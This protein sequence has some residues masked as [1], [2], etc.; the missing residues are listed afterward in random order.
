M[1]VRVGARVSLWPLND[2]DR[3]EFVARA[4]ESIDFHRGL[5][6]APT[7]VVEFDEYLARFDGV[8]AVGF[9]VRLNTTKELAGFVNINHLVWVPERCGALGYGGFVAT[10]GHGYVAEAV[11]LVVR[12]AFDEL[13]LDRLEADIQPANAASMRVVEQAG[14]RPV[15]AA[16]Q[17][18]RIAGEWR[19]HE[20]WAATAKVVSVENV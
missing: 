10:A 19:D 2:A 17:A 14:F 6:F 13:R 9:V 5:V 3:Y 12:Y 1:N 11:R 16:P 7:T 20:R 18:I 8:N 15:A 4:R